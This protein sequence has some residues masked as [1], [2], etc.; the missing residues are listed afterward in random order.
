MQTKFVR[1]LSETNEMKKR[2]TE[3]EVA[4]EFQCLVAKKVVIKIKINNHISAV[5]IEKRKK[6]TTASISRS[7]PMLSFS[8]SNVDWMN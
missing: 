6:G 1:C 4:A 2:I 8:S 7:S 3:L 5:L